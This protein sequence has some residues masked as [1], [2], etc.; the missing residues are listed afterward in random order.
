MR[1]RFAFAF[2]V[3]TAA[4]L[5]PACNAYMGPTAPDANWTSSVRGHFTFYVK[6]G[7]FA[8]Q[9]L[10]QV[11]TVLEEQFTSTVAAL[12]LRYSGHIS[13]FLYNSG[14][15]AGFGAD[16][17]GGNHSGVAYPMTETVKTVCVPPLDGNV[18]SLISHESNHVIVQNGLGR[19]GTSFVNEGLASA[20]VSERYHSNGPSVSHYWIAT[21]HGQFPHIVDLANDDKWSSYSQPVSYTVSASFLAW[22]IDT[23]GAAPMKMLYRAS[24]ADFAATFQ[25]AY[26]LTLEAAEPEWVAYCDTKK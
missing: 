7:S 24:S 26:G 21:H 8:E 20:L 22:L 3:L 23:R 13:M 12:A 16:G 18:F 1:N 9:S 4:A 6:P 25:A 5:L 15:D 14:D 10:D 2:V 11:S 19:P 17:D